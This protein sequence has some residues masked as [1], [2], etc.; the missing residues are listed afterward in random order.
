[1]KMKKKSNL[2]NKLLIDWES[3]LLARSEE[4]TSGGR[5]ICLNFGIDEKGRHLGNTGGHSMF[6]KFNDPL[7]MHLRKQR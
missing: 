5:F 3:I 1:M 2:K 6:D 7:E 4:L